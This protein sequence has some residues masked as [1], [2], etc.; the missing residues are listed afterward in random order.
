MAGLVG[1]AGTPSLF[2]EE[3]YS[4]SRCHE[5]ERY[6]YIELGQKRHVA[7]VKR[8]WYSLSK[9]KMKSPTGIRIHC[10]VHHRPQELVGH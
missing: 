10:E 8:F 3:E 9:I 4:E 7:L 5:C 2:L 6:A 1:V